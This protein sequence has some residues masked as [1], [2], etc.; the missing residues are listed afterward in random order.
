MRFSPGKTSR[1]G[2][3]FLLMCLLIAGAHPT[4]S[5]APAEAESP[6]LKAVREFGDQVLAKGRDVYGEKHTPLFVDGLNINTLEPVRWLYLNNRWII[7]NQ[8]S[9]QNLFR[10]NRP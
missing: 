10:P 7:S 9:Q 4:F 3:F 1:R 6:W 2:L 8:A 5:A